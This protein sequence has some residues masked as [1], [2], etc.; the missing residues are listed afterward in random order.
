VAVVHSLALR[1]N[2]ALSVF[3]LALRIRQSRRKRIRIGQ[4]VLGCK[5]L[6]P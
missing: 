3:G 1:E 6:F 5:A 2:G 4:H